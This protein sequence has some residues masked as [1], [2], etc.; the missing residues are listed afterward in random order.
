MSKIPSIKCYYCDAT[1]TKPDE[2]ETLDIEEDA[3]GKD[4]VTFK[5]PLCNQTRKSHVLMIEGEE[6]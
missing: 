3:E 2:V 1:F 5:C 4:V 6:K